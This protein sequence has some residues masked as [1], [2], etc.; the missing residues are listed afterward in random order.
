VA[1]IL[2][3]FLSH[4]NTNIIMPRRMKPTVIEDL[5]TRNNPP[6][7]NIACKIRLMIR[8]MEE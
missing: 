8:K 6:S 1:F 2:L 3:P 4:K 5:K 7:T